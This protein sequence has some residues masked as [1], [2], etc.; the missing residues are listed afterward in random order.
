MR[1]KDHLNGLLSPAERKNGWK[2]AEMIDDT[3]SYGI[4]QFLYRSP[5][6]RMR[7]G[8]NSGPTW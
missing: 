4:K 2:L 7:C 8:M 3:T 1:A 6:V 5:R